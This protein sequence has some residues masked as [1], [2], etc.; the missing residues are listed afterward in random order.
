M[1]PLERFCRK[2]E[3]A[4]AVNGA[5]AVRFARC[6]SRG[7]ENGEEPPDPRATAQ[8]RQIL[9]SLAAA[10]AGIIWLMPKLSR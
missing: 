9:E 5:T 3:A 7:L 1:L 4:G 10:T 8:H 2:K 6:G